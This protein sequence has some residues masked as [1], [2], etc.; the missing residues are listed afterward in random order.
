MEQRVIQ[1]LCQVNENIGSYKGERMLEEQVI[2]S[3][4]VMQ[5]VER[6]EEEFGITINADDIISEHFANAEAVIHM[7]Q[8]YV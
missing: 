6:L 3:F 1:I 2:D 7:M 5:M 8:R 4:D